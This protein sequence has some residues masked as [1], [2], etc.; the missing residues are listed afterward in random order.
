MEPPQEIT[1]PQE[2]FSS[3]GGGDAS[4]DRPPSCVFDLFFDLPHPAAFSTDKALVIDPPVTLSQLLS[5]EMYSPDNISR[6]SRFAFPEYDAVKST[7]QLASEQEL[8]SRGRTFGA[9]LSKYDIYTVDFVAHHHTFSLL[10]SDGRTR[11]HGHVRRYLPPHSDCALRTD[12]GR[13]RPR[14]MILLTRAMGCER[15]YSSLLKTVEVVKMENSVCGSGCFASNGKNRDPTRNFLHYVFNHHATL[16]SRYSELC[17]HGLTLNFTQPPKGLE[18]ESACDIAKAVMEQNEDIFR[19]R[20]DRL[21]FGLVAG[22]KRHGFEMEDDSLQFYLPYPLQPG[23]ECVRQDSI[24]EDTFS[25]IT[26]LLRYIGPSNMLRLLSALL[27][28]RRIILISNS[29]TRLSMCVKAASAALATGLLMWKHALIPVVPPHLISSLSANVPYLVGVLTPFAKRLRGLEGLTDVLCVN[30][31]RNELKTFNM[32]NPR[33]TVPDLLKKMSRKSENVSAAEMLA[34]DLDEIFQAD[35]KLWQSDQKS[36]G[37]EK[38][39]EVGMKEFATTDTQSSERSTSEGSIKRRSII[40]R[41]M[42]KQESVQKRIMSLEEKRQYA[43][44]IDAAAYFGQMIRA[45]FAKEMNESNSQD[46]ETEVDAPKYSAPSKEVNTGSLEPCTVAEN[47]GGEEDIRAALTCF[48]LYL[49]GD[50]GMYLSE[51]NGT[52]WLDRRKYLLRKKQE[53]EK[54]NSPTFLVLRK[55]SSSTM[56]S[57]FVNQRISDMVSMTARER[58]SIMPHHHTI[59]D[60][61]SKYLSVHRLD[62]SLINVRKIVA[63]TVISCPR[64]NAVE[65]SVALRNTAL[66]LTSD[67]PYDGDVA[68]SLSQLIESC[69]ECNTNLSCVMSAIWHRLNDT[70]NGVCVLLALQMLKNLLLHGPLTTISEALDG[71]SKIYDLKSYSTSKNQNHTREVRLAADQVYEFLVDLSLL[72]IRRRRI[73]FLKAQQPSSLSESWGSYIVNKLPFTTDSKTMHALFRPDSSSIGGR[74]YY[75]AGT[76]VAPSIVSNTPSIMALR[77]LDEHR[78]SGMDGSYTF[79]DEVEKSDGDSDGAS[80]VEEEKMSQTNIHKQ[81]QE[82]ESSLAEFQNN[83]YAIDSKQEESSQH[84]FTADDLFSDVQDVEEVDEQSS[85]INTSD[86]AASILQN[87]NTAL[88]SHAGSY[89][90][91]S[92]SGSYFSSEHDGAAK[93]KSKHQKHK[94]PHLRESAINRL[95]GFSF[96]EENQKTIHEDTV[97][98]NIRGSRYGDLDYNSNFSVEASDEDII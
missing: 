63:Q 51:S 23:F 35:Q 87:F 36:G 3:G 91:S 34:N 55:F 15:F 77:R 28:E 20:V 39:K 61:C 80:E 92:H 78:S 2:P 6:I 83:R 86:D 32:A 95:Q 44:S 96:P 43:S 82:M 26:P 93:T 57:D 38:M 72:F 59:F 65:R 37:N 11:V 1:N 45:N 9:N 50:L 18:G 12:V 47:E 25:P 68:T 49:Y 4:K 58:S 14:A 76:S 90:E 70:K 33:I 42:K 54:E 16:V 22:K 52:F 88:S 66:A 79:E 75:D 60:I 84:E 97:E 98:D 7:Q 67:A 85:A 62:F 41:I 10:L 13:R 19:L 56:F 21:E 89:F 71:V 53:G 40:D 73:A 5:E 30:I 69:R 17:R 29:I 64:H 27:C 46:E 48:F 31:D 94:S 8:T 81:V 74:L 24:P